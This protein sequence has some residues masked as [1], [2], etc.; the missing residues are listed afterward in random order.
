M[1][2]SLFQ[3]NKGKSNQSWGQMSE[4][5]WI[6][7]LAPGGQTF[8]QFLPGNKE[9]LDLVRSLGYTIIGTYSNKPF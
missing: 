2:K 8:W 1:K 6:H 9:S 7:C 3:S 4:L 5:I